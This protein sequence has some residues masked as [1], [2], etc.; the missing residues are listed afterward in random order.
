MDIVAIDHAFDGVF[1]VPPIEDGHPCPHLAEDREAARPLYAH[2]RVLQKL[3]EIAAAQDC[4][5]H[6]L[7]IEGIRLTA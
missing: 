7:C 6:D 3:R 2:P 5:P 1:A 4:K